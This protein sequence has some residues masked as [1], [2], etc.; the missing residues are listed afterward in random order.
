MIVAHRKNIQDLKAI[1]APHKKIL[2]LGCGGCVT[3]CL[4]GGEREVGMISSALRIAYR[5]DG[6][7][8]EIHETTIERQCENQFIEEI[9]PKVQE[10]DAVLSL[11]CGAGV[12]SIAER[13]PNKPVYPGVD[14]KFIG[15][16][17]EQGI[18]TEKC[19]ACGQCIV[20]FYGAVCPLTRCSK[21]QV[22]GPC[23]GARN[24]KCEVSPEID[25][26]WQ[27]IYDRLKAIGQLD[28]LL[29]PAPLTDWSKSHEGGCRKVVRE[30]QRVKTP[31]SG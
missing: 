17:Q 8:H 27:L 5:V 12:Q 2:V 18:W 24:G 15:I 6:D 21:A 31:T 29:D 1:L 7:E 22:D 9:L 14:T 25:C 16:L 3:V 11:A 23:G 26:G 19:A 13:Y 4:A 20:G 30:D 28:R 10:V